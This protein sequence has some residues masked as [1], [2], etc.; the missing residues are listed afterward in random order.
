MKATL[1]RSELIKL[2]SLRSTYLLIGLAIAAGLAIGIL[3]MTA[4]AQHWSQLTPADRAAFDPVADSFS[5]FQFTQLAFGAVGVLSITAETAT[6]TIR[7]TLL[8]TPRRLR[9]YAHKVAALLTISLPTCLVSAFAAFFLGQQSV[10]AKHLEAS[11]ADPHVLRAVLA[12][13]VFMTV[14][15]L[16]GFG[17]G[18]LIRHT[19]GA[20]V[21]MVG[22]VFLAWPLARAMESFSYLPDRLLLVNAADALVELH[23]A[24]GPSALRTPSTAV[25]AAVLAAYVVVLIGAGAWRA[26]RDQ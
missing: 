22:L 12:A 10:R 5:G 17:L 25:A 14:I 19:A 7:P 18:A 26:T 8:A 15:S 4:T 23:P 6:G 13:G 24:T 1:W 3:E 9:L 20:L 21:V 16:I 11:L 2:G